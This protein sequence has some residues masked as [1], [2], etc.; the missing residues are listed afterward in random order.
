MI[1]SF[2]RYREREIN[3]RERERERESKNNKLKR[4]R[5]LMNLADG[6]W[7]DTKRERERGR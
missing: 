4:K 3:E 7:S 1:F 2:L 6:L 5:L